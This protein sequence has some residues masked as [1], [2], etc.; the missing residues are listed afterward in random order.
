M[1]YLDYGAR[2]YDP[3]IARWLSVDPMA[4]S[5]FSFSP[6]HFSGNNPMRFL[7]LN[8]MNYDDYKLNQDGSIEFVK[9]TESKTDELY[10]TKTDGSI[11]KSKSVS[12]TK[13]S[14]DKEVDIDPLGETGGGC[15]RKKVVGE[16][17][18]YSMS[19]SDAAKVFVFASDN[20]SIE[21]G[22]IGTKNSGS[23]V[24]TNHT[25]GKIRASSTATKMNKEGKIITEITHNHPKNSDPSGSDK[26][27]A[28]KFPKS[29]G[30]NIGYNVYQPGNKM[31]VGYDKNGVVFRMNSTLFFRN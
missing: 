9:P 24:F 21:F 2:L 15:T 5:Y 8:G 23:V 20:S 26:T 31:V 4:E 18:G 7:D 22:F 12:V 3:T 13:G 1:E 27:N 28:G 29:Q 25:E 14:F 10:A 19:N 16:G 30:Q 17:E 6:Y 11:D